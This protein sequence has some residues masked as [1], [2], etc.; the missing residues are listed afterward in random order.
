M[1][2]KLLA[3]H[4]LPQVFVVESHFDKCQGK[5]QNCKCIVMETLMYTDRRRPSN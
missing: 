5:L 3:L 2:H 1:K 4:Y